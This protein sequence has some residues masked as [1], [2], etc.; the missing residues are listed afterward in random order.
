MR[1]AMHFLLN[2]THLKNVTNVAD[3]E[4]SVWSEFSSGKTEDGGYTWKKN[5]LQQEKGKSLSIP[6]LKKMLI[7][8]P[9]N[10]NKL[11]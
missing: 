4:V 10:N 11:S 7:N 3:I 8:Y 9:I 6:I 2:E 5:I 1:L